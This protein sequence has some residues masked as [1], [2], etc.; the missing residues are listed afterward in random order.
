MGKLD[1]STNLGLVGNIKVKLLE[2]TIDYPALALGLRVDG[3]K[4]SYYVVG[5]MQIR[6]PGVRGHAGIG[7]GVYSRPFVGISSVLNPVAITSADKQFSMPLT[8]LTMEFDGR[9]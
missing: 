9:L 5:S 1:S 6:M 3:G 7:T 4:A 8:T 2:E